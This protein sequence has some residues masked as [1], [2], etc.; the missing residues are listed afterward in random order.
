MQSG[1]SGEPSVK[2]KTA[3]RTV[4]ARI[5]ILMLWL[6]GSALTATGLILAFRLL[7]GRDYRHLSLLGLDRHE[8]GGLH[9]WLAYAILLLM[10]VH[11]AMHARWLWVVACKRCSWKLILGIATGLAF[12]LAALLWPLEED[13]QVAAGTPE[14][15][16]ESAAGDRQG[17]GQGMGRRL[18]RD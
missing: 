11:L 3:T 7:P 8:W 4:V 14:V 15:R 9:T 2:R 1:G 10:A 17:Q 13:R 18:G 6:V 12:P 16:D 5:S